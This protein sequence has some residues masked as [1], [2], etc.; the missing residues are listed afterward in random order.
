MQEKVDESQDCLEQ[1]QL[2]VRTSSGSQR[3]IYTRSLSDL[4]RRRS[5]TINRISEIQHRMELFGMPSNPG[6]RIEQIK[7]SDGL[8]S[9]H[10]RSKSWRDF[11]WKFD[12]I[13]LFKS[14][15]RSKIPRVYQRWRNARVRNFYCGANDG[16]ITSIELDSARCAAGSFRDRSNW[17]WRA[18]G[19]TGAAGDHRAQPWQFAQCWQ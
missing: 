4:M 10:F 3:S 8:E 15:W 18:A 13:F 16:H 11:S 12:V 17:S 1:L 5:A 6:L 2:L 9:F 14:S 19:T 7:I